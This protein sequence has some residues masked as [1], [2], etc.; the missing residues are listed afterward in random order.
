MSLFGGCGN[1]NSWIWV[2]IIIVLIFGSCDNGRG[3]WGGNNNN[4]CREDSCC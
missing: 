4:C 2:L 1:D 3:V